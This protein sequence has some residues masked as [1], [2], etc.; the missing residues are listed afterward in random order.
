VLVVLDGI[1]EAADWDL[2]PGII[3]SCPP[4]RSLRVLLSARLTADRPTPDHWLRMLRWTADAE[5]RVISLAP[6]SVGGV[7]DVLHSSSLELARLAEHAGLVHELFRLTAG[8]PLLVHLYAEDLEE[9]VQRR[10]PPAQV[11]LRTTVPGL[12][13]YFD[14]WWNEQ[15]ALWRAQDV[16]YE[17][18]IGAVLNVLA[19]T[20]GPIERG[21]LL[22]LLDDHFDGDGDQLEEMLD[23][24]R[25]FI[26]RGEARGG[27]VYAHPRFAEYRAERLRRDGVHARVQQSILRWGERHVQALERQ[28]REEPSHY[29]VSYYGAHLE[30]AGRPVQELARLISRDWFQASLSVTGEYDSFL[31]DV[32]RIWHA[33]SAEDSL[34]ATGGEICPWLGLELSCALCQSGATDHASRLTP[35]LLGAALNHG[36]WTV[37]QA[38]SHVRRVADGKQKAALT[39]VIQTYADAEHAPVLAS[40]AESAVDSW[41]SPRVL[42]SVVDDLPAEQHLE[43]WRTAIKLAGTAHAHGVAANTE[44]TFV[45]IGQRCPPEAVDWVIEAAYESLGDHNYERQNVLEAVASRLGPDARERLVARELLLLPHEWRR[46]WEERVYTILGVEPPAELKAEENA[47]EEVGLDH[48]EE[49]E[50]WI[51]PE[52]ALLNIN[53]D[54]ET[55]VESGDVN[56][57]PPPYVAHALVRR[58]LHASAE[59]AAAILEDAASLK[60]AADCAA[61]LCALICGP[62]AT[63]PEG[64]PMPVSDDDS[65]LTALAGELAS[66]VSLPEAVLAAQQFREVEAERVMAALREASDL[67]AMLA[68]VPAVR[69]AVLSTVTEYAAFACWLDETAR[70]LPCDALPVDL[71][72]IE[73]RISPGL[74]AA[75][76]GL[77]ELCEQPEARRIVAAG[78]ALMADGL[79]TFAQALLAIDSPAHRARVILARLDEDPGWRRELAEYMEDALGQVRNE[80]EAEYPRMH[81]QSA[82]HGD[83][84]AP[85]LVTPRFPFDGDLTPEALRATYLN[86]ARKSPP[87]ALRGVWEGAVRAAAQMNMQDRVRATMLLAQAE[88]DTDLGREGWTVALD[89]AREIDFDHWRAQCLRWLA[90]SIPEDMLAGI[91]DAAM[92]SEDEKYAASVLEALAPRARNHLLADLVDCAVRMRSATV[93]DEILDVLAPAL[94]ADELVQLLTAKRALADGP[95]VVRTIVSLTR[96]LADA[97]TELWARALTVVDR[98]PNEE[99]RAAALVQGAPAMPAECVV[100]AAEVARAIGDSELRGQALAA[101]TPYAPAPIQDEMQREAASAFGEVPSD[102]ARV[103]GLVR[104]YQA[105]APAIRKEVARTLLE[106]AQRV[107]DPWGR[108]QALAITAAALA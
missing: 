53:E 57:E 36:V 45:Y 93:Q 66:A 4:T 24:V 105:A 89:W 42:I 43:T 49:A 23:R 63:R 94:N 16:H 82:A 44:A 52:E 27:Y 77:T 47:P 83:E 34:A 97:S 96:E 58:A 92:G 25:R 28:E 40:L 73:M 21:D 30:R 68:D 12:E 5:A 84:F 37:E 107:V 10:I 22:D 54:T 55:A 76:R 64:M 67:P 46:S 59:E 72:L 65:L 70:E 99:D 18:G 79:Q 62:A 100:M 90:E 61:V 69:F 106:A 85:G 6:L 39:E 35:N 8:D 19:C 20:M 104:V 88:P 38:I 102:E 32:D 95:D 14:D 33:A 60:S 81:W 74:L 101:L 71:F 11:R 51:E 80:Q 17:R 56:A 87:S 50:T 1:D 78:C 7:R 26:I 29:L 2:S 31:A 103:A 48:D 86:L 75:L 91:L 98:L 3:P 15:R 13:A 41:T 9:Q 108:L